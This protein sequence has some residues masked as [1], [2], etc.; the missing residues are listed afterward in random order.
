[1]AIHCAHNVVSCAPFKYLEP[2]NINSFFNESRFLASTHYTN[3]NPWLFAINLSALIFVLIPKLPQVR[4]TFGITIKCCKYNN[5]YSMVAPPSKSTI[6]V[7]ISIWHGNSSY[8]SRFSSANLSLV[9]CFLNIGCVELL[10]LL[11]FKLYNFKISF[12]RFVQLFN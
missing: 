5:L 9:K 4:F 2:G 3:Y 12:T 1:M 7:Q 6:Y 11:F 10:S 8:T